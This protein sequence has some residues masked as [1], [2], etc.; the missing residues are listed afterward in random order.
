MCKKVLPVGEFYKR[1]SGR[2]LSRCRSCGDVTTRIWMAK[3]P[4]KAREYR[5]RSQ[6]KVSPA[7]FD[8]LVSAQ[9]GECPGCRRRLE[10]GKGSHL[11]HRH[12]DNTIRG[13]LCQRCNMA[14]GLLHDDPKTFDRLS[15]YLRA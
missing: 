12:S 3:N 10:P 2:P 13:V 7:D 14:I 8:A 1:K 5:L 15:A 9:K 6:F 11:D 4:D